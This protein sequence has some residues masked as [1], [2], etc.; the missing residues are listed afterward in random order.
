M[1]T[2]WIS[3]LWAWIFWHSLPLGTSKSTPVWTIGMTQEEIVNGPRF[4][5]PEELDIQEE[6]V[7]PGMGGSVVE[8]TDIEGGQVFA[9]QPTP[10]TAVVGST[11]VLPCRV[12]NKVGHLQ[13]TK[14]GFGLGT[15]RGLFG[16]SR[17]TM[18]GSDDEGDYSLRIQPVLIEDDA[19]YQC[20]VSAGPG[21]PSIRSNLARL[22]VYV[23]PE[24][25][26][27]KPPVLRTTAG[28]TVTLECES[29]GGRPPPEIQWVDD[30]LRENIKKG[31]ILATE[32]MA[33]EKRVTVRSRLSLTPQ[34][35]HHNSTITCLTSNQALTSPLTSTI[36]LQ[37]LFPPEVQL[38]TGPHVLV[39]GDDATFFCSA[40][41][42]PKDV[43]YKWY[44][45]NQELRDATSNTLT[46]YKISRTLH[47]ST[48]ACEVSNTVGTS[49]KSQTVH[50]QYGPVFRSLPK[51]VA[52]E[53]GREAVLKCDVDSNPPSTIVWLQD[54]SHKIIGSGEEHRVV[55]D[56]STAGGYRCVASVRGFPELL[57][58][59]KVLVK[60]PPTIISSGDQQGRMGDTVTLECRTVSIPSPI[61]ITWTYKGKQIDISE[62]RYEVVEDEQD[63]GLRN[64]LVIHDADTR[65]FGDYNCSV[66]NEYGVARK[67]IRL[68]EE[69][70]ISLSTQTVEGM[71]EKP[72]LPARTERV[73]VLL[74]IGGGVVVVFL[75]VIVVSLVMCNKRRPPDKG[76]P[77][78][79]KPPAS[80][81]APNNSNPGNLYSMNAHEKHSLIPTPTASHHKVSAE[82]TPTPSRRQFH[83]LSP[84]DDHNSRSARTINRLSGDS[85]E[86]T[87][88]PD[89]DLDGGRGY[90]PF[91]DYS[92]KDYAP[93]PNGRRASFSDSG[94]Y[95]HPIP[96]S[97][98]NPDVPDFCTIRRGTRRR[99]ETT[100]TSDSGRNLLAPD[101]QDSPPSLRHNGNAHT[102]SRHSIYSS[103][104]S[105]PYGSPSPPSYPRSAKS[106]SPRSPRS[107]NSHHHH[108]SSG[109]SGAILIQDE[110]QQQQ[111]SPETKYI[112]SRDAIM[113]PG[114]L[115]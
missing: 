21:V 26:K 69:K 46:L 30:A 108:N 104:R 56:P 100:S 86:N 45:N 81:L 31:S 77:V 110:Q 17:Y 3:W 28:M 66:V 37:V 91:V 59:L 80:S 109:G 44:Q 1:F 24:P 73:P 42:N 67:L 85:D 10:Q 71:K 23:P 27:V 55:V 115:V 111:R 61:K 5:G 54:G 99:P 63:E 35:F 13:W 93:L 22:T 106:C 74:M 105:V 113:K 90:V 62:P 34:R 15:E 65:D 51:D 8:L 32:P 75:L 64:I 103:M 88:L 57:G 112:F 6:Y 29:R 48:V 78:P 47:E 89:P 52:A 82:T 92:G 12:I 4:G 72:G 43:T 94:P 98:Q 16:F 97:L 41:A 58:R 7:G 40:Q 68:N 95:T 20:Q 11:V 33:D 76:T 36:K 53:T 19:L 18:I 101:Y 96:A 84:N 38:N 114:T 79:E 9:T 2:W 50:V 25:P 83:Q 107:L 87:F 60:G 14:D 49:K 39:E 102:L 70:L